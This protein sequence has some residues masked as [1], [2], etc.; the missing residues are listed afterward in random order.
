MNKKISA[1]AVATAAGLTGLGGC[2]F[3]GGGE[4]AEREALEE[5]LQSRAFLDLDASSQVGVLATD[6]DGN[7]LPCVQPTITGGT[8]VLRS[9]E[10]GLLLVEDLDV[11]LSDVMIGAGVYGSDPIRLTDVVLRLGT[12]IVTEPAWGEGGIGATGS[13]EAD[14]LLDWAVVSDSGEVYPL[15]TQR[16]G[17]TSF[18]VEVALRDD[19]TLAAHVGTTIEGDLRNFADRV[20]LSDLSIAV[21]AVT[22]PAL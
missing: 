3:D 17:E 18:A 16:L 11:R 19:D 13:G 4:L 7:Q 2:A 10:S 21:S 9:T 8:A 22:A 5:R 15:A 6:S 20:T 14:L 12:Q 1:I